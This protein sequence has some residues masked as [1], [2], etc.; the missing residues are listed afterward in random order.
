MGNVALMAVRITEVVLPG[1][2]EPIELVFGD[3]FR[4]PVAAVFR[5]VELPGERAEVH[6]DDLAYAPRN[7][8]RAAA[9]EIDATDLSMGRRR[10]ADVAW[11]TNLEIE[12]V[13]GSD[14]QEFP[15]IGLI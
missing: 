2:R 9:V 14:G 3:V 6:A 12:L 1:V 8:F 4:Q 5:E 13:V 10:H 11:R 7:H 15:A